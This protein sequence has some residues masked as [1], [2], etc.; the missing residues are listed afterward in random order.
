MHFVGG[1]NR[2]LT[3]YSGFEFFQVRLLLERHSRELKAEEEKVEAAQVQVR[4]AVREAVILRA[5]LQAIEGWRDHEIVVLRA[6]GRDAV[7]SLKVDL[8]CGVWIDNVLVSVC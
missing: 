7:D 6:A 2:F 8:P 1:Q 3:T 4:E 5:K